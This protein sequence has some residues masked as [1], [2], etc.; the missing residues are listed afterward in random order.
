[1]GTGYIIANRKTS[2]FV[3]NLS[4]DFRAARTRLVCPANKSILLGNPGA[5]DVKFTDSTITDASPTR[6][7]GVPQSSG[8]TAGDEYRIWNVATRAFKSLR[9]GGTTVTNVT[10]TVPSGAS[11]YDGGTRTNPVLAKFTALLVKPVGTNA[12]VVTVA[13]ALVQTNQ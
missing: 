12:Q 10:A 6:A 5:F 3:Y 8:P 13:P 7:T 4:G 1:L 9:I 11:A 2:N